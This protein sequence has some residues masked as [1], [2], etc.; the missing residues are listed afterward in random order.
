MNILKT[1]SEIKKTDFDNENALY[2]ATRLIKHIANICYD[3]S[4]NE[5]TYRLFEA[6]MD[7]CNAIIKY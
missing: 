7:I 1:I 3:K 6:I 4:L 2:N 5:S